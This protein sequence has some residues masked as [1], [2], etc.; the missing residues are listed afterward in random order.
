MKNKILFDNQV[1]LV[2]GAGDGLGEAYTRLLA[3]RGAA[4]VVH[5][6]GVSQD[7][8]GGNPEPAR[9]HNDYLSSPCD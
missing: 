4:L 6:G 8:A 1:V 2:T 3:E 5:D 7:G 9:R